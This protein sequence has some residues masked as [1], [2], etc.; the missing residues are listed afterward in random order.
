MLLL[1]GLALLCLPY[2]LL[3]QTCTFPTQ[4]EKDEIVLCV[5]VKDGKFV[6]KT[7][8]SASL[9]QTVKFR[10]LLASNTPCLV[11]ISD[12]GFLWSSQFFVSQSNTVNT[13]SDIPI[14]NY[15]IEVV[16]ISPSITPK[17]SNPKDGKLQIKAITPNGN[18]VKPDV[19]WRIETA[20][21]INPAQILG[22]IPD[23]TMFPTGTTA[24][25]LSIS[26]GVG[27]AYVR[28]APQNNG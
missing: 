3:A 7:S 9:F 13:V 8:R 17:A 2:S 12:S 19:T 10:V 23:M 5:S 26:K 24:S 22:F 20:N 21:A 18:Y 15:K 28:Y 27:H 16:P 25:I 11:R 14:G 6:L 4:M 1:S